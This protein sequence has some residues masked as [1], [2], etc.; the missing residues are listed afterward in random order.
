MA[1]FRKLIETYF[2]GEKI[3]N[4]GGLVPEVFVPQPIPPSPTPTPSITPT[5]TP[6]PTPSLTPTKTPTPTPTETPVFIY[7]DAQDC[8]DP[9]AA[10]V[11]VK[12]TSLLLIGS[13]VKVVGDGGT[14]Y[15]ILNTGFP[16]EDFI[17]DTT[18]TDCI[19]CNSTLITP[20]PTNTPTL[21]PTKTPT[22]TPT[23]S[24]LPVSP[25][26]TPT[27]TPT[28]TLTPTPTTTPIVPTPSIT[29]SITPTITPTNNALCPQQ[30]IVIDNDPFGF[31]FSGTYD[32][33][34]SY[35]GG[36]FIGG[37]YIN[38][39]F[40]PGAYL[41]DEY[42]IYGRF[43]G[44]RYFTLIYNT[45]VSAWIVYVSSSNYLVSNPTSRL[46]ST[47]SALSSI[48]DGSV[49]Y[50]K[51]G[52]RPSPAVSLVYPISCPTPTPTSTLTPTP[53]PTPVYY[54]LLA[55]NTDF[56]LAENEDNINIEN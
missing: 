2:N 37:T 55:E 25:T 47:F 20:T 33:L 15:E 28:P 34:Y 5:K 21:T 17:V 36:T 1:R 56:I 54:N 35:T 19:D 49:F 45:D 31:D 43:D 10:P 13:S 51:A 4:F 16:P 29:P 9:F 12:S 6:T 22:P 14:C 24:A 3:Y 42:A 32:R 53:T 46:G 44:V 11:V 26:A 30:V 7:Y 8:N 23:S 41:G 38:D 39:L 27:K 18:Y 50:P 52:N 48:T 40:T